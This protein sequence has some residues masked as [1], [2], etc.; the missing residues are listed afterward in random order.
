MS[1][2]L[3]LVSCGSLVAAVLAAVGFTVSAGAPPAE[4][5]QI[6]NP[7]VRLEVR[8]G[9]VAEGFV[10]LS[11]VFNDADTAGRRVR[12]LSY[13]LSFTVNG[14]E[15]VRSYGLPA[16]AAD[17]REAFKSS[18]TGTR[19]GRNPSPEEQLRPRRMF[20]TIQPRGELTWGGVADR[21]DI[22]ISVEWVGQ[23]E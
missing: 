4:Q 2:K 10:G 15:V 21:D 3:K 20:V 8:P 9:V 7:N 12:V 22:E 17:G 19:P 16:V 18:P 6:L 13:F 1:N 11:K 5:V 14:E 23:D